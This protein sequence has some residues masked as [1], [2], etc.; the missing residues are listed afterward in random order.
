[1]LV[2]PFTQI[3]CSDVHFTLHGRLK[4]SRLIIRTPVRGRKQ[5]DKIHDAKILR[6]EADHR[7]GSHRMW[8]ANFHTSTGVG[9]FGEVALEGNWPFFVR[10]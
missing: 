7:P 4:N 9:E 10:L 8:R 3:P 1:M 2:H 6:D 5:T